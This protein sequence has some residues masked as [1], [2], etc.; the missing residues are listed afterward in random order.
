[1]TDVNTHAHCPCVDSQV[2]LTVAVNAVHAGQAVVLPTDTVYGI[3]VAPAN[4]EAVAHLQK[5]KGRGRNQPPPVLLGSV[6]E[7]EWLSPQ[8]PPAAK[9]LAAECWPGALTIVVP[10]NP[11]LNWDLGDA[12]GTVAV[13]MPAHP[14]AL[15][16]LRLTGPLAVSSANLSGQ[17]PAQSCEQ[18]REYFGDQVGAYLDGG[19]VTAGAQGALPSTIVAFDSRGKAEILR[20]GALSAE[21]VEAAAQAVGST[22]QAEEPA[23]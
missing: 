19:P 6:A 11:R 7:L 14:K 23:R 18:A 10:L 17:P 1:M 4:K 15:A 13:R 16:L 2:S 20:H 3:G 5:L 9:A 12:P 21:A 22:G 8:A